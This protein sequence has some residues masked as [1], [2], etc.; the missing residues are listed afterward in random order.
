M[1][2]DEGG[3]DLGSDFCV[4]FLRFKE[5]GRVGFESGTFLERKVI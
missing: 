5:L 1:L 3:L 2:A 4:V